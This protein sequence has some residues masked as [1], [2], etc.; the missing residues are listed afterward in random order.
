MGDTMTSPTLVIGDKNYSSWSLRP[1]LA[2]RCFDIPF[3]ERLV[4]LYR[5]ESKAALLAASPPGKVPVLIDGDVVIWDSL[6]ILEYLA[7]G[8]PELW[9]RDRKARAQARALSAE[10]HA[11]FSALRSACPM[12]IRRAPKPTPLAEDVKAD[13]ARIDA[14]LGGA[15]AASGGPFLFGEFCA[16]DA[17]F[18]P[19]AL[20]FQTYCI[21]ISPATQGWVAAITSLPAMQDW[22]SAARAEATVLEKFEK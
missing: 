10:M 18:A 20:R 14:A 8:R 17:M 15:L 19:I 3:E 16:A 4:P 13:I 21:D 2:M 1:W 7:E 12:N 6:A 11:G 22:I 5:P 9:P